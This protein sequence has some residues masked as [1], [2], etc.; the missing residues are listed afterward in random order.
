MNPYLSIVVTGRND[1]YGG[2]FISRLQSCIT[3]NTKLL[4]KYKISTE[5]IIVNWNPIK[6]NK[7]LK[8]QIEWTENRKYVK[9]RVITVPAEIHNTFNAPNIRKNVPLYEYLAK[10]TGIRRAKGK[11]ILAMNPDILVSEQII[12]KIGKQELKKNYFY[13]ANRIDFINNDISQQTKLWLKGFTYSANKNYFFTKIFN[14]LRC[15]WC[16]NSI[17]F[18]ILFQRRNWTV[19]YHNAEYTYHCNVSGDF[20]LMYSNVWKK[21]KG[22]P[23]KTFLA[24]HTDALT[25]VMVASS[26]LKEKIF[27]SPIYHQEHTRRFDATE[28]G[29]EENRRAYLFFQEEAQKMIKQQKPIIYNDKNWGLANFEL[30]E[31][32][33]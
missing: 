30:Q 8:E 31:D 1:N 3:W 25:V 27:H 9:Y 6:E 19:Y 17:Q 14:K 12:Q 28:E 29:N 20:I 21:L 32:I 18:E 10:N 23:E 16:K 5:F 22:N 7:S 4:E 11:F 15:S 24:L 2:D 26:G 33:F 13:R